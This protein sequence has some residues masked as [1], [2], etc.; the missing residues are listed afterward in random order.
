[1]T[2][3]MKSLPLQIRKKAAPVATA[4]PAAEPEETAPVASAPAGDEHVEDADDDSS[5]EYY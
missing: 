4:P 1:M 5:P 3:R 2:S